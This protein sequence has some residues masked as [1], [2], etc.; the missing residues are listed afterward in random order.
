MEDLHIMTDELR[1]VTEQTVEVSEEKGEISIEK[2][3]T[4]GA[5]RIM[6]VIDAEDTEKQGDMKNEG[7]R[8]RDISVMM[9]IDE[10]PI[11]RRIWI[12]SSAEIQI[13]ETVRI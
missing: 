3:M 2:M 13:S 4:D 12:E 9:T 7:Q 8:R 5:R 10:T 6:M 1:I 11:L